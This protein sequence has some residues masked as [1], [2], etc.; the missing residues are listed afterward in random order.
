V[1]PLLSL[2]SALNGVRV[3]LEAY[4]GYE[5]AKFLETDFAV[6]EEVRRRT[7]MILDHMTRFEDRAR[8][9]GHRE[10]AT[11]AKR[12]KEALMAIGEDVQFAVSGVPG[13]SH[14][15]IGRLPRGP[16]K[17]LVNHDL[18]S[19]KMLVTATQAANDLLEAQLED[20]AEDG[21]LKRACAG[22]HDKVGR[23]RNHLRERGMFID[24]LMK[25]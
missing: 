9:A 22:V 25:R 11:E 1:E 14:G 13:S 5:R 2:S 19:L 3:L 10:A 16:R 21:A 17:K 4:E 6:R 18:R 12:C 7:A 20:G 23:A 15:H 8:D 24:G